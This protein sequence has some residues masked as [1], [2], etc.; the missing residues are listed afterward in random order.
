MKKRKAGWR[1][2]G[3]GRKAGAERGLRERKEMA[4]SRGSSFQHKRKFGEVNG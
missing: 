4:F 2:E 3:N 1:D